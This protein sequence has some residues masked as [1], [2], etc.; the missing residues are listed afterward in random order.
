MDLMFVHQLK[1]N[2]PTSL[3]LIKGVRSTPSRLIH[4]ERKN[5]G[6]TSTALSGKRSMDLMAVHDLK[7]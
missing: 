6:S 7:K 5:G 1:K 3:R 2:L 4:S